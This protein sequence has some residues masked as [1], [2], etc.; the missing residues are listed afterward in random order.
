MGQVRW[1]IES[2][3]LQPRSSAG[4]E[5]QKGERR[6]SLPSTEDGF[7]HFAVQGRVRDV[8]H[9]R[10]RELQDD[11]TRELRREGPGKT[12]QADGGEQEARGFQG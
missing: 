10:Q 1:G 5:A 4:K 8:S 11:H 6:S 7:Q 9:Q 3:R 2:S 12:R